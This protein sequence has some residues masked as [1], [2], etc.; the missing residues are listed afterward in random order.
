MRK[1]KFDF[2]G[3]RYVTEIKE[4]SAIQ[5]KLLSQTSRAPP[6]M[7]LQ[8]LLANQ[9]MISFLP[10]ISLLSSAPATPRRESVLHQTPVAL[11]LPS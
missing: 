4:Y 8:P 9:M 1:S 2:F 10:G 5:V 11:P 6:V 7:A 3:F